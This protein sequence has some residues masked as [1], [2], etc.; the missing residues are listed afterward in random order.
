M[1]KELD[2]FKAGFIAGWR[3]GKNG[4]LDTAEQAKQVW[5]HTCLTGH[6][7]RTIGCKECAVMN[8]SRRH[9]DVQGR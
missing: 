7:I 6:V 1:E 8:L 3:S 5:E 2:P 9:D 4:G